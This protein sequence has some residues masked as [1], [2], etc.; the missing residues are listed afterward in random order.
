[1]ID[2]ATEVSAEF[3]GLTVIIIFVVIGIGIL[4][5]KQAKRKREQR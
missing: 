4:L 3:I 2:P 5:V 1:M